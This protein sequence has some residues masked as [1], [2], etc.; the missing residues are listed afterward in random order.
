VGGKLL[1]DHNRPEPKDQGKNQSFSGAH[2]DKIGFI[3]LYCI[4]FS[5]YLQQVSLL[6]P[7]RVIEAISKNGFW[8]KIAAGPSV[9]RVA[10]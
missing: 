9:P 5:I 6:I 3:D 7:N 4:Y 1:N 10:G 2:I 8:F